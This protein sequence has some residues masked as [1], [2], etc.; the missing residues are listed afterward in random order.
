[1][2]AGNVFEDTWQ[3]SE[4]LNIYTLILDMA[5]VQEYLHLFH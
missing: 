4:T 3:I 2:L 1:M 5:F